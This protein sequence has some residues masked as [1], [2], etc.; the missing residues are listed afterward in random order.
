MNKREKKLLN[1]LKIVCYWEFSTTTECT[2]SGLL[3]F[4]K[5]L[6]AQALTGMLQKLQQAKKN[7]FRIQKN[8]VYT[9][10]MEV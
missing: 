7:K 6:S 5:P 4:F 1:I 9:N 3:K 10:L 8:K 2:I